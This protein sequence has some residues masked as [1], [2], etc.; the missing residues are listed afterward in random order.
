MLPRKLHGFVKIDSHGHPLQSL[1]I[2]PEISSMVPLPLSSVADQENSHLKNLNRIEK[3]D[4]SPS[5]YK[6]GEHY[7]KF[8][9]T[10]SSTNLEKGQ[11]V[12]KSCFYY[13]FPLQ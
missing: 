9:F 5:C 7:V 6:S 1:P 11:R 13:V 10:E 4:R 3:I 8:D 2:L 12:E